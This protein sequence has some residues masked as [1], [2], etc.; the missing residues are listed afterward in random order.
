MTSTASSYTPLMLRL[1][2]PLSGPARLCLGAAEE[3]DAAPLSPFWRGG[4]FGRARRLTFDHQPADP[5]GEMDFSPPN[6]QGQR[7]ALIPSLKARRCLPAQGCR[8]VFTIRANPG[9]AGEGK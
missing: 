9:A 7:L 6:L 4:T 8:G 2:L 1:E 5:R 3:R